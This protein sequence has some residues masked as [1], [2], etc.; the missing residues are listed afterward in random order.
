MRLIIFVDFRSYSTD[1]M[2]NFYMM[3][4]AKP[5]YIEDIDEGCHRRTT[6]LDFPAGM[7]GFPSWQLLFQNQR[8]KH[9]KNIV[10]NLFNVY[11]KTT[12]TTWKHQETRSFQ[13]VK[14]CFGLFI[15]NFE[16][17][18]Y[19]VFLCSHSWL[20]KGKYQVVQIYELPQIM[21]QIHEFFDLWLL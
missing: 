20:W 7:Y 14:F 2:C 12:V 13:G 16:Q 10:W 18:F 8:H 6:R 15:V 21:P 3:Y 17:R 11:N 5:D 4:Y 19:T 1:E 9:Q